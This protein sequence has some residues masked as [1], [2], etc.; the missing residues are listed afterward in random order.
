[1]TEISR[2]VTCLMPHGSRVNQRGDKQYSACMH[3]DQLVEIG[4]TTF[5]ITQRMSLVPG[6]EEV[7]PPSDR[8][9]KRSM[10]GMEG[11]EGMD[12]GAMESS[13]TCSPTWVE[14]A[15]GSRANRFVYV[16]CNKNG[17]VIEISTE[18]WTVT[19]RF[20]TGKGPYNLEA[21]PDGR[22]LVATLKG[23]RGIAI[24]DLEEGKELARLSTTQ[25]VT[26]GV[27]ASPDSRYVFVSNEAVGS[28][29]GTLDVFD[30][31]TLQRGGVAGSSLPAG[32]DRFLGDDR[33]GRIALRAGLPVCWR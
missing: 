11:M 1:M 8:G 9:E 29:P 33:A 18:S 16:A 31:H 22:Y 3:S 23:A 10:A 27:V 20:P 2:I 26:H 15:L 7:L 24:F 19:R 25:P 12:H 6:Q 13:A 14:P 32:R 30:L 28:T 4:L 17:E 21:T 5:Q